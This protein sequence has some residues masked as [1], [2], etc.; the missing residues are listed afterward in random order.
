MAKYTDFNIPVTIAGVKFRN[1]FYVSSGPLTMTIEQLE[2]I[3]E[4]GW[5]GASLKLTIDPV[6][7][8][9][10]RPRYGYYP[11][12]NFL[13]FTAEKRLLLK[14][15]LK[16][17]RQGRKRAPNLVLFANITYSGDK[18]LDGWVKMAK[19]C[20]QAGAHIIEL[21]MCC[22]NMSFNV[23]LSGKDTG[24]PKTGAS[25]G[26]NEHAIAAIVKAVRKEINIPLFVK[27]TAEGGRQSDV[28]KAVWD[29]GVDAISGNANCL[30]VP[31]INLDDPT[32]S[33]YF[34]QEEIGL[35]CM[36][37]EW[38]KPLALRQM[39]DMRKKCGKKAIL[40][41]TGGVSK[42]QDAVETMMCGADLVGIC[43]AALVN[44]FGFMPEFI[45]GFKQYM[46]EKGYKKPRDMRDILIPAITSAPDLT[47][48]EG[49]A[50]MKDPKLAAPCK[51]ACPASVPAQ[52]YVQAVA[53]G[54][55]R[56]AYDAIVTCE[57]MQAI[58][59]KI[60][61]APCEE[62][63]TRGDLDEPV[64]IRDIKRLLIQL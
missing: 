54:D 23:E 51:Y 18:G 9:N 12:K 40:A 63:C 52:D 39:Y 1:P 25:L 47:I 6:P 56:A 20:E 28:A 29:T 4:C 55:F 36:N 37:G 58:C 19:R 62:E 32:K 31:P 11:D 10:R 24:G 26:Q 53:R 49:H 13:V 34:L 61:P 57:P 22:P 46:K 14:E 41:G 44:G 64:R 3:D 17:I 16:L 21:N 59:G 30:V 60:C 2:R 43:T 38:L 48:Y 7:Y 33:M 5:G 42:W 50:Q 8:I 45:H 15:L 35:A 27:L